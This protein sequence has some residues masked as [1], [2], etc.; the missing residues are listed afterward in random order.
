MNK[1]KVATRKGVA[2]QKSNQ[3]YD[4]MLDYPE[5]VTPKE[6][7]RVTGINVNT[8]KSILPHISNIKRVMRGVYKVAERGD[9]PHAS[10]PDALHTWNF[11]NCILTT[12]LTNFPGR[13][14]LTTHSLILINLEFVIST[15]GKCT[16]R[17]S[18]D[19]PVNVS[20][21]CLVYGYLKELLSKYSNDIMTAKK[22][23]VKTMEFN[24]D[25]TN[26]RLDGVKCITL[27]N[28][29]EQFK[30]YQKKLGLRIEHKTKIPF[31]VQSVTDMLNNDPN[32][33]E[34]H[35]KLNRQKEQLDRLTHS[36][37]THTKQ[38]FKVIDTLKEKVGD[39]T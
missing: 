29:C 36:T 27:D 39:E 9:S 19:H 17:L 2:L 10:A 26:L 35:D 16:I 37:A 1:L 22:V 5:G 23:K 38:L 3:I 33:L 31:N 14:I 25:Y 7:S 4:K 11:H 13:L 21:I 8:I 15:K 30:V 28:L 34:L 32:S 20:A 18:T 24:K 12:T 6:L